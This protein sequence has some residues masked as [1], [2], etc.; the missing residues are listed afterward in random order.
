MTNDTQNR[1]VIIGN[2][3]GVHRGHAALIA[4]ARAL[5][6]TLVVLTFEPHPRL[7]FQPDA[8]PF[9]LTP[10]HLKHERLLELG[11]DIIDAMKFDAKMAHLSAAEFI[12]KVIVKRLEATHVVVGTDFQ[13]GHKR[14]G[15]VDTLKSDG[16]FEVLALDLVEEISSTRIR[17]YL[18][19]GEIDAANTLLGWE[20]LIEGAVEHGDKR[21][22][23]L[24]Y[25]TANIRLGDNLCPA[26]GVYAVEVR[27]EGEEN[28]RMGAANI[29]IRPM[30]AVEK[31]LLEVYLLDFEGDL[32][33]QVL[34][35]RPVA[36]LRP[37]M[38]FDG[39]EAL[40]TQMSNDC[41]KAREILNLRAKSL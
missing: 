32:Y 18:K 31:P 35:V 29:G 24:G 27:L 12:D 28:W 1:V 16:R 38:K 23:D 8:A 26:Y 4:Y 22:R 21:G 36:Y 5:G 10:Q 7:F 30:F 20:W 6:G 15:N 33:G 13:F 9:R 37:E 19:K 39:L 25:P 17:E 2:F 11:A 40:K 41:R 34:Q 3:D 14:G